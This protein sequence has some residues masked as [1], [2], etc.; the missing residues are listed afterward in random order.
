MNY[1]WTSILPYAFWREVRSSCSIALNL[2]LYS[3]H[4]GDGTKSLEA[5]CL[6]VCGTLI[7]SGRVQ[8][9]RL[10]GFSENLIFFPFDNDDDISTLFQT[11]ISKSTEAFPYANPMWNIPE[12]VADE[13]VQL[14]QTHTHSPSAREYQSWAKNIGMLS[15]QSA[16]KNYPCP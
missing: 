1:L 14:Y 5:T 3:V 9:L 6:S 8:C 12:W 16:Q 7:A 2:F 10:L 4:Q 11:L 15:Q 13:L